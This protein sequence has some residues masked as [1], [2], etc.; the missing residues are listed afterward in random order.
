MKY[1]QSID[2]TCET[3]M[4]RY[5]MERNRKNPV[6]PMLSLRWRE[7]DTDHVR[8]WRN[9]WFGDQFEVMSMAQFNNLSLMCRQFSIP[10][11]DY[12]NED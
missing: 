5:E 8:V 10:L 6:T 2:I 9:D 11:I 4:G 12:S 1:K 3:I 7:H